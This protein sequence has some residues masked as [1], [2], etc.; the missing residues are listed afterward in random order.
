MRKAIVIRLQNQHFKV[1]QYKTNLPRR[2]LLQSQGLFFWVDSLY[3]LITSMNLRLLPFVLVAIAEMLGETWQWSGLIFWVKPLLMPTLAWWWWQESARVPGP[4]RMGVVYALVFSTLGDTLLMF[5]GR[6][7]SYFLLGLAAFLV[8][9]IFYIRAFLRLARAGNGWVLGHK[10]VVV[11]FLL[12]LTGLLAWLWGGIPLAMKGAVAVY[13]TVITLMALT[14]LNLRGILPK[15]SAA[16]L[17]LGAVLFVL[18]D[19]LIAINKFGHPFPEARMAIMGTY[20][21]GQYA[22]VRGMLGAERA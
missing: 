2:A 14:A 6:W 11:C 21:F 1:W 13:A 15:K 4:V 8:A 22:I 18:S 12:Y 20:I 19:S 10:W 5:S 7:A 17:F 9:H 16:W 3:T